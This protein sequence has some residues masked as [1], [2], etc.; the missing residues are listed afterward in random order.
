ML[1]S[2]EHFLGEKIKTVATKSDIAYL[3]KMYG[4]KDT[5]GLIDVKI[6]PE[7]ITLPNYSS[8]FKAFS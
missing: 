1:N 4:S 3:I 2:V 8:I 7:D 6:Q 5:T